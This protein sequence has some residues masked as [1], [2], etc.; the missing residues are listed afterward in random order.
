MKIK[1]NQVLPHLLKSGISIQ[2]SSANV[3]NIRGVNSDDIPVDI[4]L[5]EDFELEKEAV[6]QLWDFANLSSPS[7][8]KMKCACATPDF[9]K[10]T[11]IPIGS[12]IVSDHDVVVP[13][14][15][16]NDIN[17]GM[18]LHHT[19]LTLDGFLAKKEA[20]TNVLKG[21]LLGGTRDLP[22]NKEAMR[23]MFN[24]GLGEFWQAMKNNPKGIF[25]NVDYERVQNELSLIHSSSFIRGNSNYAPENLMNRDWMR[26]PSL[27]TLGSSNHFYEVQVVKEIVDR[28]KAY[29]L[30]IKVGDVVSMIHTGSRDV[31]FYI[32]GQWM[33]KAKDV[34]PKH[35][36]HPENKAFALEGELVHEYMQAMHSAAHYAT[37][38][39][40]L[41]AE[42]IRQRIAQI[43]GK[44]D[45]RLIVDVP[46]N[47]VLKEKIGNV[48]RK[49]ATPAYE[50]ELLLI[51]GSM[52]HDSYLLSGLGNEK[53]L[54]SA[55]HGAG[56]SI[57]RNQMTFKGKK[58]KNLLGLDGVECITLKEERKI[59]EAPGAY[60]EIGPVIQSQ[61]E[62]GTVDVVAVFSPLMTF[63]A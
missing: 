2:R 53:W 14:A 9:H 49:G 21:D 32:G 11:T 34:F 37:T 54:Q 36:K 8:K 57:S 19:G 29:Q 48:H 51:P 20:F 61:V 42:V 13:A 27:G 5:P 7:G 47:I 16:G 58:N 44:D 39:R 23:A 46:H 35:L 52:G 24:G 62:E 18:R 40:A 60:K 33:Q 63:K 25:N 3:I 28:K 6:M 10:G 15:I 41:I 50:G 45:D 4:L 17:C 59:E 38:N 55:S 30:G 43:Y 26:D 56:R 1:T 31:G 22:T 12:V